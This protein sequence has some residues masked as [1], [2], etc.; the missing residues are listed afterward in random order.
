[1]PRPSKP[2]RISR[3]VASMAPGVRGFDAA[4]DTVWSALDLHRLTISELAQRSGVPRVG[5]SNWLNGR[6]PLR[7]DYLVAVLG[8][9]GLAILPIKRLP[10]SAATG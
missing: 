9:L 8:A 2:K 4:A 3:G 10:P 6:R 5:L 1:M 7:A